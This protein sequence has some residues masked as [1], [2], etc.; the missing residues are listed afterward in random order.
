MRKNKK[1]VVA[2]MALLTTFTVAAATACGDTGSSSSTGSSTGTESSTGSS[3]TGSSDTGS[4]DTGSSDT[5]SSDTGSSDSGQTPSLD[6]DVE[7]LDAIPANGLKMS[8]LADGVEAKANW[9]VTYGDTSLNFSVYVEDATVYT[10]GGVYGNDSVEMR[11]SKVQNVNGY[12]AGAISVL[13]D[14][15]GEVKVKNL[16]TNADVTDS[17]VVATAKRFSLDG[18]TVAGWYATVSVP[19]ASTEVDKEAKD[20]AV[21]LG[22]TNANDFIAVGGGYDGTYG[23][24]ETNVRTYM[25]VTADNTYEENENLRQEIDVLFAGDS[26]IDF[27][28]N[29]PTFANA[30]APY[31]MNA[32]NIGV[33]GTKIEQWGNAAKVE[34]LRLTYKP[35]KIVFH[36]GVNDVDDSNQTADETIAELQA[37]YSAYHTAFPNAQLYWVSHIP[38]TMF[39]AK[40][41]IYYNVNQGMK[42]YDTE[43][44]WFTYIDVWNA[45]SQEGFN[46]DNS[47]AIKPKANMFWD[48][49]HVNVEYGYPLWGSIILDTIGYAR[50]HG[51]VMGDNVAGNFAYTAGWDVSPED[52][53]EAVNTGTGETPI[54]YSK[55]APSADI[56]YET[57]LRAPAA[58]APDQYPKV[59]LMLR[60]DDITVFGYFDLFAG[61]IAAGNVRIV[62]RSNSQD[63]LKA[64]NWDWNNQS[65]EASTGKNITEEYVKIG[66]AKLNDTVYL[67]VNGEVVTQKT[68]PALTADAKVVAG[69]V[70]FNMKMEVKNST[71]TN[72]ESEVQYKLLPER[73]VSIAEYDNLTSEFNRTTAKL[74]DEVSFTLN[75]AG[76]GNIASVSYKYGETTV[77]L[78]AD[79]GTY[80]FTMPD[81]D[82]SILVTFQGLCSLDVSAVNGKVQTSALTALEGE[83][84]TVTAANGYAI[85]KLY[86]DGVLL[87]PET[88][89]SYVITME[90]DVVLTGEFFDVVDGIILDGVADNDYGTTST[91]ANYSDNRTITV[92]AVKKASGVFINVVAR[93]NTTKTDDAAWFQ[94]TNFEFY[95]NDGYQRYLNINGAQAGVTNFKWVTVAPNDADTKYTYNVEIFVA[96]EIIPD[97]T[98]DKDVQLN[99][100]WKTGGEN[101]Q[102][103]TRQDAVHPWSWAAN[104]D[105]LSW[106]K[107]GACWQD[108]GYKVNN[109][110]IGA[111]GIVVGAT[112]QNATIDGNLSEYASLEKVAAVGD[113]NKATLEVAGKV[114]ADG[115]YLALTITHGT[116]S[117]IDASDW[118]KNDNVEFRINEINC[119]IA[120]LDGELYVSGIF[121]QGAAVTTEVDGKQVTTVELFMPGQCDVYRML[122][123]MNG[124]GFGGWQELHW[125]GSWVYASAAG[126]SKTN[127]IEAVALANGITID[128]ELNDSVYTASVKANELTDTAN[129]ATVKTIGVKTKA[130]VLLG[131]TVTHTNP[132]DQTINGNTVVNPGWFHF[133]GPEIRIAGKN[134]IQVAVSSYNTLHEINCEAAYKTTDNGDGTYTTVWE[135]LVPY[136]FTQLK[137]AGSDIAL[138]VG[139]VF[140]TGF[141]QIYGSGGWAVCGYVTEN[142]I[143][144]A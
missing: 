87:T 44:D 29:D 104:M 5:G 58:T 42:A 105:W 99:Y 117:T 4:S 41:T 70:G 65:P 111:N 96:K 73:S 32:V 144:K 139:G 71:G 19:Y 36:I 84:I 125:N 3:D 14:A 93:M 69:V 55:L 50:E 25:A 106:H 82:V 15:T 116:W 101:A 113:T 120:F 109:L 118:A 108:P 61:A 140:E 123:G 85:D 54:Y 98:D 124:N 2:L 59:G 142:G 94:N 56:Y 27:W 28:D 31:D 13:V 30:I 17:G 130:G 74:G 76:E 78:T 8:A 143:V 131:F 92:K 135:I 95:L 68:F 48:G 129:G 23:A 122:F 114:A 10:D 37:M 89:G 81:A 80:T 51:E 16:S 110:H 7:V 6:A 26:Y 64:D 49:L 24:D 91:V 127:P 57:E 121:A 18:Q 66:I 12:S 67:L 35:S 136:F 126:T 133:M 128:G 39:A 45:F 138:S 86:A 1:L 79:N 141:A 100:A 46:G 62:G 52:G 134:D 115:L 60:N 77:P 137:D 75:Y 88:D 33:G 103:A 112:A 90:K 40:N 119:G 20:A 83:T 107:Y 22:L 97:W 53:N 38:N 63:G 34:E 132:I 9:F 102:I 43:N 11:I 47:T 72:V 21:C